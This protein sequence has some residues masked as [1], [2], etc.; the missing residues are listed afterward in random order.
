MIASSTRSASAPPTL[1]QKRDPGHSPP[2]GRPGRGDQVRA[3]AAG[4]V[5][6]Q[7]VARTAERLHLAGED[8]LEPQIVAR[9]PLGWRCPS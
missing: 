2:P 5:Q 9:R 4:A 6:D 3:F 8:L 1:P 7:E